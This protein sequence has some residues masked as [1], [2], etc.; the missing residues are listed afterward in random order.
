MTGGRDVG[1]Q[2]IAAGVRRSRIVEVFAIVGAVFALTSAWVAAGLP[3]GVDR[4]LIKSDAPL[5]ARAIIC[6]TGG[7][8]SKDL[9]TVDGWDRI[10]TAMQL[11]AD[12]Y[13]P[14]IVISGGGPHR[15]SE[16]EI[17]A[18]AAVWLGVPADALVVDP[19]PNTTADHPR[20]VLQIAA[21]QLDRDEALDVVTSPLH[22]RRAA[23]AFSK[24]GFTNV[25]LVSNWVSHATNPQIVRTERASRFAAFH[26]Y[27]RSYPD[28]INTARGR[29]DYAFEMTREFAAL[30]WYWMSG[31]I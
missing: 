31:R 6:L 30:T 25:R 22:S 3:F 2:N 16:A 21:L 8:D 18:D 23:L 28:V 1:G 12:G 17:Y 24:A 11:Y 26:P 15:I 5:R 7:V 19:Y 14:R 13:A 20:T 27:V 4:M 10:Y 9:P 29:T